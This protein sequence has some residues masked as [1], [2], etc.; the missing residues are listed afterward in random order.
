VVTLHDAVLHH[1]LLG[2]LD[3]PTYI[4]E[5]VYNYGEW[6]R[7]WRRNFGAAA[8]R[9]PRTAATSGTPCYGAWPSA[10]LWWWCIT[11]RG[12][13]GEEHAPEARVVEIPIFFRRR[14]S[15]GKRRWRGYRRRLGVEPGTFLFGV[16]GF[17]RE[18]KRLPAVLEA[19]ADLHREN[20]RTALLVAGEF[21]ST[22]WN[23]RWSHSW[24]RRRGPL[25][26]SR[27]ARILAGGGVGGCL[28]QLAVSGG[29]ET[30]GSPSG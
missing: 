18:S 25:G 23:G 12:A 1:F 15:L 13:R 6:N 29:G 5:F 14:R 27:G 30:S 28:H 17:L 19:F 24:A 20:P 21:V 2:Q 8:R 4:E 7:G 10:H 9:R 3:A 26:V 16:F 11:R 22:T